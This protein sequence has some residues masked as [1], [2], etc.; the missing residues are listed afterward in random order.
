MRI[1]AINATTFYIHHKEQKKKEH[2]FSHTIVVCSHADSFGLICQGSEISIF[3]I[4]AS[5]PIQ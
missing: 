3:G 2:I 5:T 1:N 4:T